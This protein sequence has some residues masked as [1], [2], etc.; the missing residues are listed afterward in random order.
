[1]LII[2]KKLDVILDLSAR[3]AATIQILT[4][5]CYIFEFL[6]LFYILDSNAERIKLTGF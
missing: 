6:K 5:F 2:S 4:H 1:M 3:Y